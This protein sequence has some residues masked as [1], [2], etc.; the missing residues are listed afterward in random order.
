[1][2]G[3]MR[4]FCCTRR[5]TNNFSPRPAFHSRTRPYTRFSPTSCAPRGE[6]KANRGTENLRVQQRDHRHGL[7]TW[8]WSSYPREFTRA[9]YSEALPAPPNNAASAR[10]SRALCS[11]SIARARASLCELSGG[12]LGNVR[13]AGPMGRGSVAGSGCGWSGTLSAKRVFER[14]PSE[15]IAI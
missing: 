12:F 8:Q 10:Y 5:R 11:S 15:K 1:M 9:R 4:R 2:S 13:R 6:K 14:L 3:T 7:R